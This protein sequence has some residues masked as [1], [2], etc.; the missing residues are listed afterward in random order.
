MSSDTNASNYG[1]G[2]WLGRKSS[3]GM[4]PADENQEITHQKRLAL[5]LRYIATMHQSADG[6]DLSFVKDCAEEET[7]RFLATDFF[8]GIISEQTITDDSSCVLFSTS[9]FQ[10]IMDF[11]VF[12]KSPPF[13]F[14]KASSSSSSPYHSS[15]ASSGNISRN[16]TFSSTQTENDGRACWLH[17][18]RL[19]IEPAPHARG[20]VLHKYLNS[21]KIRAGVNSHHE[22]LTLENISNVKMNSEI[23]HEVKSFFRIYKKFLIKKS[24]RTKLEPIYN[25]LFEWFQQQGGTGCDEELVWGFGNARMVKVN[26]R[27]NTVI[28]G[29]VLEILVEVDL[30]RDGSL[31][32]RPREHTGVALNRQVIMALASGDGEE[33]STDTLSCLYR[34]VSEL[35]TSQ[36]SPGQPNT[37]K[38]LLKEIAVQLCSGGT[39]QSASQYCPGEGNSKSLIIT[40]SWCLYHRKKPSAVWARDASNLEE[41]LLKHSQQVHSLPKASLA[42]TYGPETLHR[43]SGGTPV[44]PNINKERNSTFSNIPSS[45]KSILFSRPREPDHDSTMGRPAFP[46]PTSDSQNQIADLLLN[47]KYPAVVCEGPPGTGKTHT[48]ANIL[49]AYLCKGKRVLITSKGAPALSVLRQ[50][51]PRSVQELTVDVSAS[52]SSGMRQLQKTVERMADRLSRVSMDIEHEKCS[53]LQRSIDQLHKE[54]QDI[55][56]KLEE[57]SGRKRRILLSTEGQQL[58]ELSLSLIETVPWAMKTI[59]LWTLDET[60]IFHHRMNGLLVDE[61]DPMNLVTNFAH[62]PSDAL[63]SYVSAQAGITIHSL[64]RGAVSTIA[65]LPILGTF[66]GMNQNEAQLFEEVS[67]LKVYDHP[68]RMKEDWQLALRALKQ[69][70]DMWL[71]NRDILQPLIK[72]EEW[73]SDDIYSTQRGKIRLKKS[74][75]GKMSDFLTVKGLAV[76]LK[77][78]DE[79]QV[80]VESAL[81]EDKRSKIAARTQLLAEELVETKVVAELSRMFSTEAQSALIRFAQISGKARFSRASQDPSKMSQR[82]RRHRKEYLESFEKCVR[83]IPCWVLTSSQISDYLPSEFGLFDLVVIDEAS[84]SDVKVLPGMLRGK[85]WLIVGDGKQVSPSESF[86]SETQINSL[87]AT[88]PHGPLEDSLL[89]GHSFFDLCAQA[90]PQGRVVLKEHFRCAPE[91][92]DFSN[93]QFYDSRLVPLRLPTR[94]ER[95][96]PSIIDVRVQDGVKSGKKNDKECDTIVTMIK[97]FVRQADDVKPRSIGIIS[98]VGSEQSRL[99]RGR[100]LDAIGAQKFKEHDILVGDPPT[101][102]GAER[103]IVFLSLVC[104]PSSVPSQSQLMHAQ[105]ANVALSRARD[106]M[107][108]VRSIDSSHIPSCDDIKLPIIEFFENARGHEIMR[109]TLEYEQQSTHLM[110]SCR[111]EMTKL[112]EA[113]LQERGF[114]VRRMS[115]IWNDALSVESTDSG[116][117]VALCIDC[118]GESNQEWAGMFAQ[119]KAIERVGW[120]CIRV[121]ALSMLFNFDIGYAKIESSLLLVG[122]HPSVRNI[123]EEHNPGDAVEMEAESQEGKGEDVSIENIVIDN[124]DVQSASMIYISSDDEDSTPGKEEVEIRPDSIKSGDDTDER[125][126]FQPELFGDVVDLNFLCRGS[127]NDDNNSGIPGEVNSEQDLARGQQTHGVKRQWTTREDPYLGDHSEVDSVARS[128]SASRRKK[129]R[130]LDK[131][132]RDGRWYP[133][134]IGKQDENDNLDW[135]DTDSDLAEN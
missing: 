96:T 76:K 87:K 62:P 5:I 70:R 52:E 46:L 66:S 88:L 45:I 133:G 98:L 116:S 28:N 120:K 101:F 127:G 22:L 40:D 31:I 47:K 108:L 77:V 93:F 25:G 134:Q 69:D 43:Q 6:S 81:L 1:W 72:R 59:A 119:Q 84:Q 30:A 35:E 16:F 92:I 90:F 55:D 100:L 135:Y 91:I 132:S 49:C 67:A 19:P 102:Q 115:V 126:T 48:I 104:S 39:F 86:I 130:R 63:I 85:Q 109:P 110:H 51:L 82:Q 61:N 3:S 123:V 29:P 24:V 34:T 15:R 124:G 125:D 17:L 107:V 64:R 103:D 118:G 11:D 78:S 65:A 112:I 57:H 73:P 4:R 105:R 58:S 97:D 79:I 129:Y 32:V 117:R 89:P 83:Y 128:S 131:Y 54:L 122:V 75:V 12:H 36:I 121:D 113:R 20:S 50:R 21:W 68:P 33:S 44:I 56:K 94:S 27:N 114:T 41:Q 23:P 13:S 60:R 42:L 18:T 80:S 37:Y 74:F 10:G 14:Y 99:I 9:D 8:H 95:L 2:L 71:F 106:R 53:L 38:K 26:G 111:S 7:I